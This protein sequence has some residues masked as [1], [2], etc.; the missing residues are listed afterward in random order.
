VVD[1]ILSLSDKVRAKDH[2]LA[3]L[4]PVQRCTTSAAIQSFD[5]CHSKTLLIKV[6]V[7]ELN[8]GQTLVP[9]VL[10]V[11][12]TS[13]KHIF[14]NLIHSLCFTIDLRMIRRTVDQIRSQGSMQLLLEMS[15]KLRSSVRNDGF[16]HTKQTHDTSNI[17]FNVLLSPIVGV[18]QNEMSGLGE[19]INDHPDGIKLAGRERETHNEIYVDVIPFLSM[20]IQRLQ[21][22]DR[23]HMIGLDPLAC[24]A[25]CN[26]ASSLAL[27][28]SP[29]ELCFQIMINLCAAGMDGIFRSMSFIKY[30]PAQLMVLWN[31]QAVFKS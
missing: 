9:F 19:P 10:I 6:V 13:L 16:G 8:Q 2:P 3:R 1:Y 24:V 17:Q 12:H 15:D 21:Q 30:L 26:I 27:H 29:P 31:H 22:S 20:N 14:K 23:S 4:D 5:G 28:L 25:F 11:Q 18:H 7:R